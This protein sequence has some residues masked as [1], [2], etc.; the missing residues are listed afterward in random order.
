MKTREEMAKEA[1][2]T[3]GWGHPEDREAIVGQHAFTA[4]FDAGQAQLLEQAAGGFEEYEKD[5]WDR[6]AIGG[7]TYR[8]WVE[9][10]H[11]EMANLYMKKAWQ[12]SALHSA[13]LLAE[14]DAEIKALKEKLKAERND[15]LYM[16]KR[17][18]EAKELIKEMRKICDTPFV[19]VS[20]LRL[21]YFFKE[22][23]DKIK[24]LIGEE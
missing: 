19:T 5:Y 12:A 4:G 13:K 1:Y 23:T 21:Q 10:S 2:P 14:K 24:A 3:K 8:D 20:S 7:R 18:Y 17:F 15:V 16:D 11:I 9:A 6:D 22:N